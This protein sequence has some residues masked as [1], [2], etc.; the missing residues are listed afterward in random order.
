MS[1]RSVP[2][3]QEDYQCVHKPDYTYSGDAAIRVYFIQMEGQIHH[4]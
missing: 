4:P 3:N 1:I 2:Q